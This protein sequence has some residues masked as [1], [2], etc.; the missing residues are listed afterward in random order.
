M[1]SRLRM[2]DSGRV[3]AFA[4]ANDMIDS[5][6]VTALDEGEAKA[7]ETLLSVL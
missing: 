3:G 2:A 1:T 5:C 4:S 7:A 6:F